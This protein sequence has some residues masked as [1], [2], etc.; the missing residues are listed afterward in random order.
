MDVR[1]KIK[2][3]IYS[4][5]SVQGRNYML[6]QNKIWI[7]PKL[8]CRCKWIPYNSFWIVT[9]RCDFFSPPMRKYLNYFFCTKPRLLWKILLIKP[10]LL[11]F[12]IKFQRQRKQFYQLLFQRSRLVASL[13]VINQVSTPT[14][15]RK[16]T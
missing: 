1:Q 12:H 11:E 8:V 15:L 10:G 13:T 6:T 3:V 4:L 2:R 9:F 14:S 16:Y 5:A 7:V